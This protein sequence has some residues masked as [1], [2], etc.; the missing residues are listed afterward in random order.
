MKRELIP[1]Q[2]RK[3]YCSSCTF[4]DRGYN[5]KFRD[6]YRMGCDFRA[7][8]FSYSLKLGVQMCLKYVLWHEMKDTKQIDMKSVS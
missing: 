6:G 7:P 8:D 2:I 3:E 4:Y 1:K 5:E